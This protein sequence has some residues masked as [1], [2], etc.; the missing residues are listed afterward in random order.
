MGPPIDTQLMS[1]E[2]VFALLDRMRGSLSPLGLQL[3]ELL[4]VSEESVESVCSSMSMSPDAVYAWRSRL[5]Q[6]LKTIARDLLAASSSHQ[7]AA[8]P[9]AS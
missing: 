7:V 9:K 1:R 3:F 4:V 6:M 2:L 8:E 5:S